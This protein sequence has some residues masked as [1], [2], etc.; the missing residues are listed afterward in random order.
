MTT[1]FWKQAALSLPPQ[2]RDRYAGQIEAAERF[3]YLLDSATE[4]WGSI[5][6]ALAKGYHET[7]HSL[8]SA[9]RHIQTA[10]RRF[11]F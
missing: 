2:V 6:R 8:R 11:G 7:A 5:T 10:A 3:E 1:S 4:G 9:V